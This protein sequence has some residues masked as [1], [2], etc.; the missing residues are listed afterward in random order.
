MADA[1]KKVLIVDDDELILNSLEAIVKLAGFEVQTANNGGTAIAKIEQAH[2][3]AV[4]L[5][6]ILPGPSGAEVLK[7]M[8]NGTAIGIPVIVITAHQSNHPV[9]QMAKDAP[10]VH[11]FLQKPIRREALI[12]ALKKVLKI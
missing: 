5:D 10:N 11:E 8:Q 7:H 6:L 4:I 9:V 12:D 2:P 1:K 3:D